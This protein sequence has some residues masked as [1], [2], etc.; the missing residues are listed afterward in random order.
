MC[1]HYIATFS[2]CQALFVANRNFAL[3]YF[4]R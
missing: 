2:C 1:L 4:C 3:Y